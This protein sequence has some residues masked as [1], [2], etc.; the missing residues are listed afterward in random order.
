[1][2]QPETLEAAVAALGL[3]YTAQFVPW[4]MSRGVKPKPGVHDYSINWRVRIAR[5]GR[6]LVTD[7]TQGI[8]HLPFKVPCRITADVAEEVK[9]A[10]ESG[11][12]PGKVGSYLAPKLRP[13]LLRDVLYSLAADAEALNYSRFEEWADA[14]GYDADSR[15]AEA[16]YKECLRL[17][18]E[19]RAVLG[20]EDLKKLQEATQDY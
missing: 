8:G 9:R 6:A 19:L 7:Y 20:D 1:M 2:K 16:T 14:Y 12:A 18:L 10:C 3:E 4:S 15:K 13:P 11:R 17:A 5:D